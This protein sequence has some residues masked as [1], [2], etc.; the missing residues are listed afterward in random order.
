MDTS[1]DYLKGMTADKLVP[2]L[3]AEALRSVRFDLDDD[4]IP[5]KELEIIYPLMIE[6][7]NEEKCG[8]EFGDIENSVHVEYA[9]KVIN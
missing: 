5:Y 7:L 6:P 3:S 4:N 2:F 9:V 1:G 8:K